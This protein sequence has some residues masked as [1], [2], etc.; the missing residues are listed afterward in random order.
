M[1][2]VDLAAESV[3]LGYGRTSSGLEMAENW[4]AH[5]VRLYEESVGANPSESPWGT[6]DYIAALYIRDQLHRCIESMSPEPSVLPFIVQA[7]DEL[8][9]SF[10]VPD[11]ERRLRSAQEDLPENPWWWGRIPKTGAVAQELSI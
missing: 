10:T 6:H 2:V 7:T 11:P 4:A 5:V 8:F 9:R 3:D 1:K